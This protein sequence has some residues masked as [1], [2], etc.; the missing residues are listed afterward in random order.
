MIDSEYLDR[1]FDRAADDVRR[2]VRDIAGRYARRGLPLTWRLLHLIEEEALSDLGLASR[3][4]AELLALFSRPPE[5]DYPQSDAP[6]RLDD[7]TTTPLIFWFALEAYGVTGRNT[8]AW[9]Q[10]RIDGVRSVPVPSTHYVR[11]F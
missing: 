8:A 4:G 9:S 2:V 10:A 6:V 3:H 11:P 7:A 1:A 5:A